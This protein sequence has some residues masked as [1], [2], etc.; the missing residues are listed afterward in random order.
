MVKIKIN[1][2]AIEAEEGI[3]IL[4]AAKK[5]GIK[6]PSLCYHPDIPPTS[7]CGICIVKLANKKNK[8][9]RACSSIIENGMDI[10]THDAEINTIRKG[11]LELVLSAHPNDCLNCIRNGECELQTAAA[12]FGV[13]NSK[14][15]NIKQNHPKDESA[16]SIVLN[17]EKCIKC[18]RCVVVCQEMQ[19]VHALGFV[20]RGFDTYFAPG[21]VSLKDSTCVDCGQCASHCPV[22][23][24]YEYDQTKEVQDAIDNPNIYVTVQMAPSVRV[25]LGEYFGLKPGENIT[26]KIYAAMRLMGFNAVFD[27]NFGADMTIVEEA[28]EFVKRFT[29]SNGTSVMTTSCCPAW[30]KYIEEYYPDLLDNVSS[31]KSP[32]MMLAPMTKTYYAKKANI[33]PETIFNVSIMPCTAKK[34]EIRKNDTMHSSGYK[35]V[36]VVITTREFARMI[37]HYGIDIAGIEPEEADSILGEYSGA[38]TIFGATGGVMEAALRTAYNIIAGSNLS[39]VEFNDVRGLQGVKR[40]SVKV[41]DKDVKIAVVNGLHNVDTVMQ[42]IR[43]AKEKGENPPYNFIEVMACPGGC[44]GGGGQPY[45]TTNETRI[46]RAKGLYDEDKQTVKHRCSHDNENLKKLYDDYLGKPLG[47][48]AHHFLHTE[49]KSKE[50]YTK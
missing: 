31:A 6:I 11:V 8:Y 28:H 10:I 21:A 24:I 46:D 12:D 5:L 16:G 44:V 35:D 9:T 43:A 23:A 20:N 27:T 47:E 29:E 17:P 30:V 33:A 49:Y 37:K 38:G 50:K 7:A 18:G 32:H 34:N 13:R 25:A 4:E 41:L 40:A 42:E 19:N 2:K 48:K 36:D 3:T 39:N 45:G 26:G 22:A 15:D 14:Y 1:G